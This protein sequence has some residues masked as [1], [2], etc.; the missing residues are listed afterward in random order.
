MKQRSKEFK[1]V[2]GVERTISL[3]LRQTLVCIYEASEDILHITA[4][5]ERN[6]VFNEGKKEMYC[7]QKGILHPILENIQHSKPN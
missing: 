4:P 1:R 6:D 3:T 7:L 5:L 2:F